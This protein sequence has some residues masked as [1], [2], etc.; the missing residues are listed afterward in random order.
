M[1][2]NLYP[3]SIND[4]DQSKE[5]KQKVSLVQTKITL[6]FESTAEIDSAKA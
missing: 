1:H 5:K 4:N 3:N 2:L 6:K